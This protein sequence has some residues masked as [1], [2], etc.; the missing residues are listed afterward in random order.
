MR[1]NGRDVAECKIA[2]AKEGGGGV[3]QM[4]ADGTET[5]LDL[6]S[7]GRIEED[8]EKEEKGKLPLSRH[9]FPYFLIN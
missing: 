9:A 5:H 3:I 8:D 7:Q 2:G 6:E 4:T 1:Q